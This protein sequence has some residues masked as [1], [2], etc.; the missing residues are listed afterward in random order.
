MDNNTV[1]ENINI[2]ECKELFEYEMTEVI[3]KL[4]GEF[5]AVSGCSKRYSEAAVDESCLKVDIPTL[6]AVELAN[7]ANYCPET[8]PVSIRPI[9]PTDAPDFQAQ[10]DII[11]SCPKVNIDS[12]IICLQQRD[13]PHTSGDMKTVLSDV[14]ETVLFETAT[15]AYESASGLRKSKAPIIKKTSMFPPIPDAKRVGGL[16]IDERAA[17]KRIDVPHTMSCL[18][19]SLS[20]VREVSPANVVIPSCECLNSTNDLS[21]SVDYEAVS[22]ASAVLPARRAIRIEKLKIIRPTKGKQAVD[23]INVPDIQNSITGAKRVNALTP[24][25]STSIADVTNKV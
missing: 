13:L 4:K 15:V 24:A 23:E 18:N 10:L 17:L 25:L 8:S 19:L 11:S 21:V 3:I 5:A 14:D 20:F 9:I 22:S 7:I 6:P 12:A 16:S 1:C 2:D